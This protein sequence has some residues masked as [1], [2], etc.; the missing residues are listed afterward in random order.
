MVS[1]NPIMRPFQL[2]D[3]N[4][5]PTVTLNEDKRSFNPIY[6]RV[7]KDYYLNIEILIS[8]EKPAKSYYVPSK[9]EWGAFK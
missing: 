9:K 5:L 7:I 3:H 6:E 1:Q 8:L 2:I 4:D